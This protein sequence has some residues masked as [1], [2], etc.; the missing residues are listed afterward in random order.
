MPKT[1]GNIKIRAQWALTNG[2]KRFFLKKCNDFGATDKMIET[3]ATCKIVLCDGT[4]KSP[5][6]PLLQLFTMFGVKAG[7]KIPLMFAF[8]AGKRAARFQIVFQIL[9]KKF[10]K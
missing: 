3:L 6:Q 8:M 7:R 10:K 9:K 4:F 1:P 5:P 2:G